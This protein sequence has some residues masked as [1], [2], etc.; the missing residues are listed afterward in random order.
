MNSNYKHVFDNNLPESNLC[1]IEICTLPL[2]ILQY[3]YNKFIN[4]KES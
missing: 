1:G 2:N 4:I 3:F